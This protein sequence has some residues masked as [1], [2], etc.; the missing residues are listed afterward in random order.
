LTQVQHDTAKVIE[1]EF[2]ADAAVTGWVRE[3][4]PSRHLRP[5]ME[6]HFSGWAGLLEALSILRAALFA[7]VSEL[8]P[9][10]DIELSEDAP[11]VRRNRALGDEQPGRDLTVREPI[12]H[13]VDDPTF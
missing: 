10:R 1:V 6:I 8:G 11:E 9:R 12:A 2:D 5:A 13:E 7:H 4:S 3:T